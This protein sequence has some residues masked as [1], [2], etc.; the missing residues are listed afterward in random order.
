MKILIIRI[1][2]LGDVLLCTPIV[3]SLS[4][5]GNQVSI[6]VRRQNMC[7]FN[8]NPY[9]TEI[10]ALE[11]LW[12]DFPKRWLSF[13]RWI[14][15]QRYNVI[16]L[17]H[18]KPRELLF[19]SIF[20]GIRKRIAMWSGIWGRLTLHKCLR[21]G[22]KKGLRHF[23]DI[24]IDCSR[25][26]KVADDGLELDLFINAELR[27]WAQTTLQSYFSNRS[28]IGIHPGCGGNT[29]NLSPKEYGKLADLIIERTDYAVVA[30]GISDEINL[31]ESWPDRV[32][33]SERFWNSMG[34]L[35]IHQ[36]AAIIAL[37]KV[38]VVVG[39]GPLHLASA[40]NACTLSPFCS[41]PAI[42]VKVW[43]NLGGKAEVIEA[44]L[45]SCLKNKKKDYNFQCD[46]RGVISG[47]L[48]FERL[49]KMIKGLNV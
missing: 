9:V 49:I 1:D 26:L 44:P 36:L 7:I 14:R 15:L 10:Y 45:K 5:A 25:E 33:H 41:F 3:R 46:F 18:A 32:I 34:H 38:Y 39:T 29:C 6:I 30:T 40:V 35:S 28:V 42:S 2:R 8:E 20:S 31:L 13:S 23:S 16:I 22:V 37:M 4:K 19:A 43:G 24:I 27:H 48:L 17:P 12:P 47:E 11:D 21:S